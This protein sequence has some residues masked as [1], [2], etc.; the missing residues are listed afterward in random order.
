M[1]G[2][3]FGVEIGICR[4]AERRARDVVSCDSLQLLKTHLWNCSVEGQCFS[5]CSVGRQ[6]FSSQEFEAFEW[7]KLP[8]KLYS[9]SWPYLLLSNFRHISI[10]GIQLWFRITNTVLHFHSRASSP[11]TTVLCC[12]T[13]EIVDIECG[14]LLVSVKKLSPQNAGFIRAK[15]ARSMTFCAKANGNFWRKSKMADL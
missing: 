2:H 5:N 11:L 12:Y 8:C 7:L 4:W 9:K 3:D 14:L 13:I 15:L 1:N 6:C 10:L